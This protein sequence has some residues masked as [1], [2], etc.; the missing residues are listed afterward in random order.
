[1]A[2]LGLHSGASTPLRAP[3]SGRPLSVFVFVLLECSFE[4]CRSK[5]EMSYFGEAAML[6]RQPPFPS[7]SIV[8]NSARSQGFAFAAQ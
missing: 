4:C 5:V 6:G 2:P 3:L 7:G 8:Q 1:M